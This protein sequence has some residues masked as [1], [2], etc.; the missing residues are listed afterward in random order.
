[1]Y[2]F[3]LA[4]VACVVC[5]LQRMK[6]N[7]NNMRMKNSLEQLGSFV[8]SRSPSGRRLAKRCRVFCA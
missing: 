2:V 3:E 8:L 6:N 4:S 5:E 1:M 7:N